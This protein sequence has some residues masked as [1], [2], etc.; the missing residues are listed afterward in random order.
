[1]FMYLHR[2]GKQRAWTVAYD[3]K[4]GASQ[5]RKASCEVRACAPTSKPRV[6]NDDVRGLC[7]RGGDCSISEVL[8][9]VAGPGEA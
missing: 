6:H 2:V 5:K 7:R 4:F 3:V 8:C 9:P 1:M